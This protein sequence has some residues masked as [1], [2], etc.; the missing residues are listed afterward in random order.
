METVEISRLNRNAKFYL[1]AKN[2]K[3]VATFLKGALRKFN[4]LAPHDDPDLF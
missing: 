4:R 2:T 3:I 1:S